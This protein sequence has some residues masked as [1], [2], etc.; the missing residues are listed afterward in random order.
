MKVRTLRFLLRKEFLQILRDR[1]ILGMLIFMPLIQ[2]LVLANAV[3]FEVRSASMYVIDRDHSSASRD[4]VTRLTGSGR[5]VPAG[6]SAT[7]RE[8][9]DAMLERRADMILVI[10]ANFERDLVRD[11]HA[12]VQLIFNAENGAA[13]GVMTSYANAI[14][15]SSANEFGARINPTPVARLSSDGSLVPVPGHPSIDLQRRGWYNVELD[16]RQYM[17]PGILVVLVTIVGTLLTA[18]NIVREKE[19][20]TLDQLNV[21]PIDRSTFIAAKLIPLWTFAM[22]DLIMGLIVARFVFG[23]PML[24]SLTLIFF[25]ATIYMIGALGIGL[26]ISTVAETQQQAMFVTFSL[27]MIYL[28]MSG[29][30]TPIR[31]MPTWAQWTTQINP[32]A[33]FVALMRSVLLKG[34][35]MRDVA[36]HLLALTGISAAVLGIAVRK[37]QKRSG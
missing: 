15:A 26:W 5:F 9:D 17:V 21:T 6:S 3:T 37:Y 8:A 31:A 28:L 36:Q 19:A 23:V 11:R 30:F 25:A 34:A 24:G 20:G 7:T 32:I 33:H 16:Y 4:V 27:L 29:L 35:T 22:A 2:L 13:A 10:P 18:M 12:P 14:L 1:T